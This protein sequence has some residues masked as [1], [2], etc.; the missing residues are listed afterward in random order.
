MSAKGRP[1]K[2]HID[3]EHDDLFTPEVGSWA[4]EKYRL[5]SCYADLFATSMKDKWDQRV[6]IDLFAGAGVARIENTYR[7]VLGTPLLALQVTHP[8]DWYVFCD[9]DPKCISA[10]RERVRRRHPKT[11]VRYLTKDVNL[12]T[13]EVLRELPPLGPG[14]SSL[15][16][17]FADPYRLRDLNFSTIQALAHRYM[18]F[19]VL[20]PAMDPI[21]NELTYLDAS[22][23]VVD[24]FVGTATW[25]DAWH[26]RRAAITFDTFVADLFSHQMRG[27]GYHHG[28]VED[29]VLVRS[30]EKNLPLYRL[31][32]FSRST[33][34]GQ[35]WKQARKYS[36]PQMELF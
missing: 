27:L 10:L 6:Y 34:G 14:T 11:E 8:F 24:L 29:S 3:A 23:A 4:E 32:F 1:S 5:L 15:A 28:G 17:C 16:F 22:S 2:I 13:L 33:L 19:M 25:R 21:R 20:I 12:K 18:D 31:G 26:R 35:F 36:H 7:C 9:Q 30:T